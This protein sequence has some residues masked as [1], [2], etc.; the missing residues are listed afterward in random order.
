MAFIKLLLRLAREAFSTLVA[1]FLAAVLPLLHLWPWLAAVAIF[2]GFLI[3]SQGQSIATDMVGTDWASGGTLTLA[4]TFL[5]TLAAS[6]FTSLVVTS[7][8]TG[9]APTLKPLGADEP[10]QDEV[11]SEPAWAVAAMGWLVVTRQALKQGRAVGALHLA[12]GFALGAA[13][14]VTAMVFFG[15]TSGI[16]PLVVTAIVAALLTLGLLR[17]AW[18]NASAWSDRIRLLHRY[19]LALGTVV[20]AAAAV[21]LYVG[22]KVLMQDPLAASPIG[23]AF[24][25]M[26]GLSALASLVG[27]CFVALPHCLPRPRWGVLAMCGV[28][29]FNVWQ[30]P[31]VDAENPLLAEKIQKARADTECREASR[32]EAFQGARHAVINRALSVRQLPREQRGPSLLFVSAEGGGI[33]AAYW[34]A[35]S[36]WEL[37]Q[38]APD[39]HARLAQL[40]GVSGGSL[41]IATW[42]AAAE[43]TDSPTEQRQLIE[44]FLSSDFLSP[45]IAGLLFLDAPRLVFGQLWP[46]ARR[47]DIFS[48]A[49]VLRWEQLAQVEPNFFLRPIVN[50]CFLRLKD[51]P[52]IFFDAADALG[53]LHVGGSNLRDSFQGPRRAL[54]NHIVEQERHLRH[55]GTAQRRTDSV[56]EAVVNSA[57]FPLLAPA[58]EVAVGLDSVEAAMRPRPRPRPG[59]GPT[60]SPRAVPSAASAASRSARLSVLVDGG[61]FDNSGLARVRQTLASFDRADAGIQVTDVAAFVVHIGNDPSAACYVPGDWQAWASAQLKDLVKRTGFTPI[62]RYDIEDLDRMLKSRPLGWLSSPL[63]ALLAVRA[64]H[65]HQEKLYLREALAHRAGAGGV[66]EVSLAEQL[67]RVRCREFTDDEM[68]KDCAFRAGFSSRPIARAYCPGLPLH[69]ELP[70]GW[71]LSRHD[72]EWLECLSG[73]AARTANGRMMGM[74]HDNYRRAQA[75]ERRAQEAGRTEVPTAGASAASTPTKPTGQRP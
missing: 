69:P 33:R 34:S 28:V 57:R 37:S 65:S 18:S 45:A 12:W 5:C 75:R 63:E 46:H 1:V 67:T 43:A 11:L 42:L 23:P 35:L 32:R 61:Y 3:S 7:F 54:S 13:L 68:A 70:L 4:I 9:P 62:C 38:Q 44:T 48:A 6:L 24:V 49:L 16:W 71:T 50:L 21:P 73:H 52:L 47:D 58:A 72:R 25:A 41:G 2:V 22:A 27:A 60:S 56:V 15:V 51:P 40:T 10:A 66:F 26:L 17:G 64:E 19:R 14:P 29:V 36:L 8:A 30:M 31:L 55:T 59:D 20:L 74:D 53:G 39:F